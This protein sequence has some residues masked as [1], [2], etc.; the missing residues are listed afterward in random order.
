MNTEERSVKLQN[1]KTCIN[2]GTSFINSEAN[3]Q[4]MAMTDVAAFETA[5]L[6]LVKVCITVEPRLLYPRL[7]HQKK[8][9][10]SQKIVYV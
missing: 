1:I 5:F 6:A 10:I 7:L 4:T 3:S 8:L 9:K 2:K